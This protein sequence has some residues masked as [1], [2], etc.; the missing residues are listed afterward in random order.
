VED[1]E[2]DVILIEE[3]LK[4]NGFECQLNAG[5]DRVEAMVQDGHTAVQD[6]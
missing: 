5:S 2:M 6:Q 3:T 4:R 1:D